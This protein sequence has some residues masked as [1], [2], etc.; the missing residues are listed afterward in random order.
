M[1]QLAK[2]YEGDIEELHRQTAGN[3]FFVSEVAT[4][5][6]AGIPATVREVVLARASRLSLSGRAVL[7]AAAVIGQRIEP[8]LL[9]EVVQAEA[10]A[11]EEGLN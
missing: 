3:P 2:D 7:N 10:A 5:G 4:S 8:W 6:E 11:V 1:R 9:Q